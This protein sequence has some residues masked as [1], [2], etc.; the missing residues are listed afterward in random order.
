MATEGGI[1]YPI[2]I[3]C[4]TD[5]LQ[6][7]C[8]YLNLLFYF[9]KQFDTF[10]FQNSNIPMENNNSEIL[11]YQSEDGQ[12]KIDVKVENDT[13]WLSLNQIAELFQRDKSVIAKHIKNVFD[14]NELIRDSSTV[15]NF[16][17]VQTEGKRSIQ[18]QV[19]YFNLDV[20]ISVGYRVKS[21][22]GTQFRIWATKRL[23]EFLIKGFTLDDERLKNGGQRNYFE[24]LMER[25]RDIRTSEKNFYYKVREIFRTSV[26]YTDNSE[27]TA[28]FYSIIQ[29]KFHWAIHQHTAAEI[30]ATRANADLPNMGLTSWQGEKIRKSDVVIA[31]N[32]LDEIEIKE[33]NL[34]VE[35]Y[36]LFAE[37][38]A[39]QQKVMYMRD[40]MKKLHDILTIN[41][42]EIL[43]DAGRISRALA[44]DIATKEYDRFKEK[45]K[46][47]EA[48]HISSVLDLEN[49]VK[50]IR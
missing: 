39:L 24:E 29:N 23:K 3:D 12:T 1:Y 35:Q 2:S 45:Q 7:V 15:A 48:N 13:V 21:H 40:W 6:N 9:L 5:K 17:T 20:I 14:E 27:D 46:L 11:I 38:Q 4:K 8:Y 47:K 43:M 33:L 34:L 30:I 41:E 28:Q 37:S 26:D 18:R 36:L 42:R 16:A 49:E 22:R 31:K 19:E 32:Y 50:K 25:I 10:V 44:E